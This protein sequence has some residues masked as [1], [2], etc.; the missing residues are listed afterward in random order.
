MTILSELKMGIVRVLPFIKYKG[1][2]NLWHF[3]NV[4]TLYPTYFTMYVIN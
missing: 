3:V 4:V 1:K 2:M